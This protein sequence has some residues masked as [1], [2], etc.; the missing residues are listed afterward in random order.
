VHHTCSG[1]SAM[2][3][4]TWLGSE[5]LHSSVSAEKEGRLKYKIILLLIG[6]MVPNSNKHPIAY[7]LPS[8]SFRRNTNAHCL[9]KKMVSCLDPFTLDN[10]SIF[11]TV[12]FRRWITWFRP[13]S[14]VLEGGKLW[15]SQNYR[16]QPILLSI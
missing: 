3:F 1:C 10:L 12:Y 2:H 4:I 6:I 13:D 11:A 9:L 15:S 7:L 14:P 16:G 8:A 5:N